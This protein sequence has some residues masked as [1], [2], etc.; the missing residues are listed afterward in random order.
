MGVLGR[1]LLGTLLLLVAYLAVTAGQVV[2]AA[3]R[4]RARAADVIVVLGAAQYDGRPSPAL[5]RRLDHALALY[6]DGLAPV[7]WTTG[8]Q[9]PG[10]RTSEGLASYNYLQAEGVPQQALYLEN[11]GGSTY[12][13]L[14]A[15]ARYLRER[16]QRRVLLVSDRWHAYRVAAI[17]RELGLRPAVSPTQGR[18]LSGYGLQRLG[19]E[20]VA[21]AVG[22]VVGYRRLTALLG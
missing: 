19:K 17:A 16:D 11:Q 13:S 14:A 12:A 7:I 4:D 6:S 1:L 2:W 8:G 10:D 20:A 21:V 9:Q 22:R 5:R 3:Q 15:A 18:L